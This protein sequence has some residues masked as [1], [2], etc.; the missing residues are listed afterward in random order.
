ML[1]CIGK[2]RNLAVFQLSLLHNGWAVWQQHADRLGGV[3][4]VHWWNDS[5]VE[6]EGRI[7][8]YWYGSDFGEY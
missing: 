2:K 5:R 3:W 8:L 1:D 6:C 7:E 4:S